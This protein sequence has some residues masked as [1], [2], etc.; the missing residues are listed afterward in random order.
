M[1]Y[2]RRDDAIALADYVARRTHCAMRADARELRTRLVCV[3]DDALSEHV[4]VSR[5]LW[6]D[7]DGINQKHGVYDYGRGGK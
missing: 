6:T 2:D 1:Y 3:M 4:H 5:L 7:L